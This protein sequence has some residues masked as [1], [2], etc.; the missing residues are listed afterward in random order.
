MNNTVDL[1]AHIF[2][3]GGAINHNE[4]RTREKKRKKREREKER[5]GSRTLLSWLSIFFQ[6]RNLR[7]VRIELLLRA[8]TEEQTRALYRLEPKTFGRTR[9][10]KAIRCLF[11]ETCTIVPTLCRHDRPDPL[12]KTTP[13]FN[14]SCSGKIFRRMR[15]KQ[16]FAMWERKIE[17]PKDRTEKLGGKTN[18]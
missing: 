2:Y 14:N 6:T 15:G 7:A 10:E 17:F 18:R 9:Y 8:R 3:G 16:K 12:E 11:A 4:G 5:R 13:L 1:Y